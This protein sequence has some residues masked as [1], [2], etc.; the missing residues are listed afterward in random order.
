MPFVFM[1][2]PLLPSNASAS[3][4][5]HNAKGKTFSQQLLVAFF[6]ATATSCVSAESNN[7]S[8]TS[9]QLFQKF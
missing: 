8:T 2:L 4:K 6:A 9:P 1:A 7:Q 3:S 5:R